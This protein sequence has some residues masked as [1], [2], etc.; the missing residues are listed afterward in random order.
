M[1]TNLT[2]TNLRAAAEA[3]LQSRHTS[4][5]TGAGIS[6]ESGIPPFR[7]ANGVWSKYDPQSL[8]LSFFHN[9]PH[10]SWIT[11]REIFYSYFGNAEPNTAHRCLAA[12]ESKGLIK[13][14][15]TQNIDNLHQ[16]AGSK[17]V[18]EFHGNAHTLVCTTCDSKYPVSRINLS[19]IPPLCILDKGVLKPDFIFFGENIPTD[20][21]EQA[22]Y[23]MEHSEVLLVI[24]SSGEVVPA[25][26]LPD[27][28]KRNRA[29]IIE[30]NPERTTFT[31]RIT[32]IFLRGKA[33]E[34]LERLNGYL[35]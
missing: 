6:V 2:E 1:Q 20:A 13:A 28:A 12:L 35:L 23:E 16:M 26:Y 33:S 31:D 14:I 3:I 4:V 11:I 25:S 17:N 18:I 22:K 9:N 5:F 10:T 27:L 32:N 8:D 29:I 30:I 24:G 7:G 19:Q 15:I 21:Y 34:I